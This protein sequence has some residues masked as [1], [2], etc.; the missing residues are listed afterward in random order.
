MSRRSVKVLVITTAVLVALFIAV[1]RLAVHYADKAVA[2]LVAEK[3]GYRNSTEGHLDLSIEGFPFLTQ[4]AGGEFDHV[5]LDAGRFYVSTTTNAQGDYLHIERLHLDLDGVHVASLTARSAEAN[6][7]TGTLQLSY[8][9]LSGAVTRLTGHGA[10]LAVSPAPGSSG[11]TARVKV[12]GTV[13]GRPVDATG[14][15]LAQGGE[16]TVTIPGAERVGMVWRVG[17]PVGADFSTTR[18]DKDGIE[19]SIVGHQV[20]L[21]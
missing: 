13:N 9:E 8:E 10:Q 14:T 7:V 21:G 18:S 6:L 19:L 3:Y 1:D 15:L 12:S 11:Q 4:A 16:I 2:Q 20:R 17:L 5:A